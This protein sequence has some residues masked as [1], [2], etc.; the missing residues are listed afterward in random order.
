MTKDGIADVTLT[1]LSEARRREAMARVSTLRPHLEDGATLAAAARHSGA[2]LRTA[3]RWLARYRRDGLVGLA[4]PTQ[5]D[6]GVRRL[7]TE[8]VALIEGL[9]LMKPPTSAACIH[10]RIVAIAG[11]EGWRAPSYATVAAILARLDPAMVAL[12][13]DGLSSF[14]D[15]FELIHRHRAG[16]LN[17]IWQ[18]DHTL[19]GILII[20]EAGKPV[21]PWLTTGLDDYSRAL[22]GYCAFLGSPSALQT[23]LALRQALWSKAEPEWPV[24]GVPD[25]LYVDHG[26]DFTSAHLDQVAAAVG[27]RPARPAA[28]LARRHQRAPGP[29]R[30]SSPQAGPSADTAA[31]SA[32]EAGVPAESL[33]GEPIMS[34]ADAGS[35]AD[36]FIATQEHK[37]FVEFAEAVC[38]NRYIGLCYGPAVVGKI[39]SARRYARWDRAERLL[40]TWG[41]R[42]PDE[43]AIFQALA[44]HRAALFT[45]AVGCSFKELRD[46]IERLRQRTGC[47]IAQHVHRDVF[48]WSGI[49]TDLM[50]LLIVDESERLSTM[51]LEHLWDLFDRRGI[52]LIF[53]GMPGMEKR[54]SR[55][56]QLYSRI[57]LAHH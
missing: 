52:G 43:P 26:T 51:G 37:R 21:R 22:A 9:G 24:C 17:A 54:L 15:R 39:N 29:R 18:C 12:A 19:L 50:E 42:E 34:A 33:S 2:P 47:C 11:R 3:E 36:A 8:L 57:G 40:A 44:E 53:I 55:Y 48:I 1:G 25:I 38:R 56:P 20:D 23:S 41:L 4:R 13:H 6:A 30:R 7:S 35:R 27:F 14:R 49:D 16:G 46:T 31:R 5:R 10:R 28:R 45:P 32:G